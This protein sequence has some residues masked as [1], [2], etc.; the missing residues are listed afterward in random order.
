MWPACSRRTDSSAENPYWKAAR[1]KPE[2]ESP[3][4]EAVEEVPS[5]YRDHTQIRSAIGL[6]GFDWLGTMSDGFDC[7]DSN[8][9]A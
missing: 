2:F 9:L 1:L 8:S 6:T 5:D 4:V 7:A 3:R